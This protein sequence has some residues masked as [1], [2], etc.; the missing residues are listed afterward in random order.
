MRRSLILKDQIEK[1]KFHIQYT[2][3]ILFYILYTHKTVRR[4]KNNINV[5]GNLMKTKQGTFTKLMAF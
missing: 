3:S 2:H 5:Y 1:E 4:K